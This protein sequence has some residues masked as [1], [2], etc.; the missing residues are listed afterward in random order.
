MPKNLVCTICS[1]EKR[2]DKELLPTKN[3]YISER[4]DE[5]GRIAEKGE[6]QFVI[7]SGKYGLLNPDE[8]IPFYDHLLKI[9][10]VKSLTKIV[11]KQLADINPTE[12]T[13]YAEP[14]EG[15]WEPYYI[16]LENATKSMGINFKIQPL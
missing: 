2:K 16:V 6:F 4:I 10:E 5:V 7:F 9:D 14:R 12:I 15:N 8:K 13:F 1:K 3:R 11:E